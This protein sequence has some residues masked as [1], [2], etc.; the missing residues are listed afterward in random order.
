M[1]YALFANFAEDTSGGWWDLVLRGTLEQ[2][3]CAGNSVKTDWA[4]IVDMETAEIVRW[5]RRDAAGPPLDLVSWSIGNDADVPLTFGMLL[6]FQEL[7]KLSALGGSRWVRAQLMKATASPP[8]ADVATASAMLRFLLSCPL[9]ALV[10]GSQASLVEELQK[11][12]LLQAE[13][14]YAD[15]PEEDMA[16]VLA[17][18]EKGREALATGV[19]S[20]INSN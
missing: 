14:A 17:I 20:S 18:T 9:P 8:P 1:T 16:T 7:C 6:S 10:H 2:C 11:H 19:S 5:K 13:F 4:H 3:I 12:G 15:S